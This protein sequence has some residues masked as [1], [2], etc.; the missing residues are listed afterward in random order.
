MT[1]LITD[2]MSY[3][4][5]FQSSPNSRPHSRR[6]YLK[7]S[8]TVTVLSTYKITKLET[9]FPPNLT[10]SLEGSSSTPFYFL[11]FCKL[12][13][14]RQFFFSSFLLISLKI[15][16]SEPITIPSFNIRSSTKPNTK[17]VSFL[18]YIYIYI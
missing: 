3:K 12:Q 13:P 17:I 9:L 5:H 14:S 1:L 6:P 10:V 11:F 7:Y 15:P 16:Q 8:S 18:F 4:L 2:D